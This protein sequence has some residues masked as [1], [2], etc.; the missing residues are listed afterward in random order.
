MRQTGE[1]EA[2]C[3]RKVA[4]SFL[5]G[6]KAIGELAGAEMLPICK[7]IG[8]GSYSPFGLHDVRAAGFLRPPWG[9]TYG[10]IFEESAD[11]PE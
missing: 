7:V 6:E 11:A 1:A 9:F 8:G 3:S 2:H 5:L 10:P 4:R